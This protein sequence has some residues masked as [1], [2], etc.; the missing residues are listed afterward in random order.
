M[1]TGVIYQ[2]F[3]RFISWLAKDN[4]PIEFQPYISL[5]GNVETQEEEM[6]MKT[7]E[8]ASLIHSYHIK[9]LD[10]GYTDYYYRILCLH[11]KLSPEALTGC[12]TKFCVMAHSR[13]ARKP[14]L[15]GV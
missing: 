9:L 15:D 4:S 5:I 10:I 6:I 8:V 7:R 2:E 13:K 14:G 12:H 1:P 3:S 11:V